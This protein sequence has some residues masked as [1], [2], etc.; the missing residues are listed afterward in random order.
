MLLQE[1]LSVLPTLEGLVH[2]ATKAAH[3]CFA[4]GPRLEN[5]CACRHRPACQALAEPAWSLPFMGR[6]GRS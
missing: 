4:F 6:E 1:R 2:G 5:A 3:L